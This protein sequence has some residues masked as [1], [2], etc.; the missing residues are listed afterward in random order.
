M[1]DAAIEMYEVGLGV[2][3]VDLICIIVALSCVIFAVVDYRIALY[4]AIL[5]FAGYFIILYELSDPMFFK[6]LM[7][8]MLGLVILILSLLVTPRYQQYGVF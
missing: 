6:P 8:F 4:I 5:F 1:F 7:A 2:G 3:L